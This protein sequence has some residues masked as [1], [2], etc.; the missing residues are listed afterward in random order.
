MW[1]SLV[2]W[3]CCS[4]YQFETKI[5]CPW[6][7]ISY[8]WIMQGKQYDKL[9]KP[10]LM[11]NSYQRILFW[12]RHM[13]A[14]KVVTFHCGHL[15][16]LCCWRFLVEWIILT[17]TAPVCCRIHGLPLSGFCADESVWLPWW[18]IPRWT[19]IDNVSTYI[20]VAVDYFSDV[21]LRHCFGWRIACH[22]YKIKI[23][24]LSSVRMLHKGMSSSTSYLVYLNIPHM[25]L[26]A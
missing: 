19:H 22:L 26:V 6:V 4:E 15:T 20:T 1:I 8:Q 17:D 14:E 16:V 21:P 11:L 2:D 7:D 3:W 25:Y 9:A 13:F 24:H 12:Y 23:Q 5:I 10:K 18:R